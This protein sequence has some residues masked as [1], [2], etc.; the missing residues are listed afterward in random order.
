VACGDHSQARL[1]SAI[2]ASD[3]TRRSL[4]LNSAFRYWLNLSL[5]AFESQVVIGLRLMK[6]AAGGSAAHAEAR[7]MVTEKVVAAQRAGLQTLSGSRP[8]TVVRGY[9]KKVRSNRRR[10]TR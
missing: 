10:L 5:L 1:R 3:K 8:T 6:L 9:R 4:T 2:I 7:R